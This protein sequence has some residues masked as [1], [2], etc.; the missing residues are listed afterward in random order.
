MD[1]LNKIMYE[2][3]LSVYRLSKN[4][5]IPYATLNDICNGKTLLEKCSAETV[6]KLAKALDITMEDLL[7]PILEKP[8]DFEIFKSNLCHYLA[9][10]GDIEFLIETMEKDE[11][12]KYYRMKRYME[13]F[14][15]LGMVDY[16]SKENGI[17]ICTEYN[18]LRNKKLKDPVFP[19]SI[20]AAC[21]AAKSDEPKIQA[22]E[23][24]IPEFKRHNIIENEVR[25]VI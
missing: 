16:L 25:N 1:I 15:L 19:R 22:L 10:I 20:L 9:R 21:N 7:A 4:S 12:R 13:S 24:A 8:R 11:I 2:K 14:Y 3:N 18:D 23:S 5:N 6:Y 17:P